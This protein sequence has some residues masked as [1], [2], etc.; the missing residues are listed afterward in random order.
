M[1]LEADYKRLSERGRI[2]KFAENR[3]LKSQGHD[4]EEIEKSQLKSLKGMIDICENMPE[5]AKRDPSNALKYS[6]KQKI[7]DEG[8]IN[9]T[10]LAGF[11]RQFMNYSEVYRWLHKWQK[12]GEPIPNSMKEMEQRIQ[13][14]FSMGEVSRMFRNQKRGKGHGKVLFGA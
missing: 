8:G 13:K 10:D 6:D 12:A 3:Q 7:R 11:N 4:P 2:K 14:G 9:M 1:K 5:H